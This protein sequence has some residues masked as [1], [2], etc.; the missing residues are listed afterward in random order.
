MVVQGLVVSVHGNYSFTKVSIN[1]NE[2]DIFC[3]HDELMYGQQGRR[4]LIV[5]QTISFELTTK[6]GR[7][8][9]RSIRLIAMP[10]V[11]SKQETVNVNGLMKEEPNG[12]C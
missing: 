10:G 4:S 6:G 2:Q 8:F 3:H 1:G 7:P 9:A 12:N 11:T 5:G